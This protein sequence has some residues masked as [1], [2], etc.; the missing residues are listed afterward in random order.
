M[1]PER[2]CPSCDT[3]LRRRPREQRHDWEKRIHCNRACRDNAQR[4][5]WCPPDGPPWS[6]IAECW[7][8]EGSFTPGGYGIM[9]EGLSRRHVVMAHRWVYE[10]FVGPIPA[11]HELDHLCRNRACVNPAHLE[12]V[13]SAE[14][15]RRSRVAKLTP[16][17]VVRILERRRAGALQ[18][19]IAAE[20]GISRPAVSLIVNGHTWRP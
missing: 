10:Q 4:R 18:R 16:A 8:W 5:A 15:V 11:G 9:A 12:P 20:F 6:E 3:T 13:V 1:Q 19:E 17:Q 14:N 2:I 7:I